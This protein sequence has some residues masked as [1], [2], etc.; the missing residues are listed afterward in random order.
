ML[1]Q[2]IT[3]YTTGFWMIMLAGALF[4][5]CL[6]ICLGE[7]GQ[8]LPSNNVIRL[9]SVNSEFVYAGEQCRMTGNEVCVIPHITPN[10]LS[11]RDHRHRLG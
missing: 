7:Y 1:H 2:L 4:F 9:I 3:I 5:L 10:K 8:S 6:P 11:F